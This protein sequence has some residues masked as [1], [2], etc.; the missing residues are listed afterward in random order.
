MEASVLLKYYENSKVTG[1]G[2][3]KSK[4]VSLDAMNACGKLRF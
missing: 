1:K 3:G 4:I 2:K